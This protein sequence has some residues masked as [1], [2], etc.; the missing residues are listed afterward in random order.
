METRTPDLAAC[1]IIPQPTIS[2]LTSKESENGVVRRI[3]NQE[4]LSDKRVEKT[5]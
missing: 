4:G 1:D 5:A 3:W 2:S